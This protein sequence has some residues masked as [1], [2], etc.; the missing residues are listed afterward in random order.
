MPYKRFRRY[1]QLNCFIC[2]YTLYIVVQR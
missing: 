1:P 2:H